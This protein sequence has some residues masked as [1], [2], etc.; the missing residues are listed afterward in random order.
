[1]NQICSFNVGFCC[2]ATCGAVV[3]Q[4]T[5]AAT[6]MCNWGVTKPSKCKFSAGPLDETV[7]DEGELNLLRVDNGANSK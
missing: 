3:K 7:W 4:I 6:L 2:I 1:M 5:N